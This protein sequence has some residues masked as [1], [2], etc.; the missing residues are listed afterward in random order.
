MDGAS[1]TLG[2]F[3][4][5]DEVPLATRCMH[6]TSVR[7]ERSAEA[8]ERGLKPAKQSSSS[9]LLQILSSQ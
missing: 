6:R 2:E 4:R 1:C 8:T 7:L 3:V 9:A 5:T